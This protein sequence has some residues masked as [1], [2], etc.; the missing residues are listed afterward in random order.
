MKNKFI[1]IFAAV[2][3]LMGMVFTVSACQSK[4]DTVSANISKDAD[5][6]QILR[7]I[8]FYN[9]ITGEYMLS[10]EGYCSLGNEDKPGEL[11]VTC[12]TGD[13]AYKK[14][15]LGLSD[16]VTYFEEQINAANVS[17]DHYEVVF[18]PTTIIPDPVIR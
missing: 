4:A 14:H 17:A 2:L 7:R 3:L 12:K 13:K 10:I 15:Y 9:G 18:R 1:R 8:V 5:N 6:F 16:N 11:S